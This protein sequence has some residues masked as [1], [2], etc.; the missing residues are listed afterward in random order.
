[1]A[2]HVE[3]YARKHE[4]ALIELH[5]LALVGRLDGTT[6]DDDETGLRDI[7]RDFT[8]DGGLFMLAFE[9]GQLVAMGGFR[10]IDDEVAQLRRLRVHPDRRGNG[11]GSALLIELEHEAAARQIESLIVEVPAARKLA[12]A[13]YRQHGY[14]EAGESRDGEVPTRLLEKRLPLLELSGVDTASERPII[15]RG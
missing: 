6:A 11:I 13:F 3:P 7:D 5:R 10:R 2:L 4:Y 1:M 12:R 15:G 9:D 8:E 14:R